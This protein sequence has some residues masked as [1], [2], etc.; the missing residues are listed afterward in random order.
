MVASQ[1]AAYNSQQ[2]A[3][4]KDNFQALPQGVTGVEE[5]LLVLWQKGVVEGGL[6]K[7]VLL[8]IT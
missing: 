1:H 2:K 5:R 4:G 6:T 8:C 7:S 3:L